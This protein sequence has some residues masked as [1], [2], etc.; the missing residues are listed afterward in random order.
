V[1]VESEGKRSTFLL[2][3]D[4]EILRGD[5]RVAAKDLVVGERV[6]VVYVEEKEQ[7]L[8]RRILLGAEKKS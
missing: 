3:K 7:K 8:A 4:T 5:T 1:Q 6:V 2:T